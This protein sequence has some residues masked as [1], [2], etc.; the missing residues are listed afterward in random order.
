MVG[1]SAA[2]ALA[3][4]AYVVDRQVLHP[5]LSQDEL[6]NIVNRAPS[7]AAVRTAPDLLRSAA[8]SV[9]ASSPAST[10]AP[11]PPSP[12]AATPAQAVE[13]TAAASTGRGDQETS[14]APRE[15]PR[16]ADT[17]R[18]A[19]PPVIAAPAEKPSPSCGGAAFALGLCDAADLSATR[20]Q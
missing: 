19:A 1:A 17:A 6:R 18:E 2:A 10:L 15:K 8:G 5:G 7:P 12:D 14:S 3:L 20:R 16:A 11:A 9:T 4:L 13:A